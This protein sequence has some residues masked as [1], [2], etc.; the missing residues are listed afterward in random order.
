VDNQE[1]LA[2]L[3]AQD[4]RRKNNNTTIRKQTQIAKNIF[5]LNKYDDC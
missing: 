4:T 2:K 5:E 1:K 3:G